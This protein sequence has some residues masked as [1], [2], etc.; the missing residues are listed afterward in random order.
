MQGTVVSADGRGRPGV[1]VSDG[2][3]VTTTDSR[4]RFTLTPTRPHV[5]ITRPAGWT[6]ERW[7]VAADAVDPVFTLVP[8]RDVYPYRFVHVSD[9]HVSTTNGARIYPQPVELGS[10]E[11]FG[12]FLA[13]VPERAP[14]VSSV[15]ATGD[16][17]DLGV[18]EEFEAL[19][20][21]LAGS[22]LPVHLVPGNH[23]HM[24][25]ELGVA[26]SRNDY[27][28]NTGDPAGYER[29]IGPRWY[30]FDLPGLHVVTV[31]WHTHELGLDDAVQNAW[32]LADLESIPPGTPWIL[33]SHDQPWTSILDV[34]PRPPLAT[35]SGHRHTSRVVRVGGTLHVNT[36]TPLFAG[37][38]FSPPSYR[39]VTWDGEEISL[40]TQTVTP[41]AGGTA[42]FSVPAPPASA[43]RRP[44]VR[45]THQL[46][47]AGHRAA[48]RVHDGV[49]LAAVKHEDEPAGGLRAL[50]PADGRLLWDLPLDSAVKSTP[51]VNGDTVIATEVIGDTVAVGLHD[52]GPRWRVPSPDP[53]RLFAWTAPCVA[54]DLVI[55]GDMSHLRAL[56][57]ATGALVWE[58]TDLSP[59]QTLVAHAA[60]VAAGDVVVVGAVPAP[61]LMGLD[62]LTGDTRW[63]DDQP[64]DAALMLGEAAL[65]TP[66]YDDVSACLYVPATGTLTAV[67]AKTGQTRWA[68]PRSLPFNPATPL[69]TA[70]G[71]VVV[72]S[73]R[74]LVLLSREDGSELWCR[75]LGH[76]SA[77]AMTSYRRTPHALFAEPSLLPAAGGD[78]LV[79]PGLDGYLHVV[80]AA[81]GEPVA[82]IEV[83][84]P[85]AAPVTIAGDL[86]YV[87]DVGGRIT[88]LDL[89]RLR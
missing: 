14:D 69:A 53:L 56:D 7:F 78:L 59:Y 43:E 46:P 25:G 75:E 81:T 11:A 37:L 32:L 21:A 44:G 61:R 65:G 42:T 80:A 9:T 84:S 79:A 70:D 55:V 39:V 86:A 30:S 20:L 66:L 16:L 48:V 15:I 45:W 63:P 82:E 29:N 83:G 51:A 22:P 27:L 36:P 35:F 58:R 23:D 74:G 38:D 49:L 5:F 76:A 24:A 50:V 1:L 10:R 34:A 47:G 41:H 6:C 4:G 18:D 26:V 13:A 68:V 85:V 60:P 28:I 2:A 87:V 67:D 3:T 77:L 52:G 19:R 54:G 88:A 40:R 57:A 31:D 73:G 17:T 33:L 71:I 62:L 72:D 8:D 89:A 64:R 12:R